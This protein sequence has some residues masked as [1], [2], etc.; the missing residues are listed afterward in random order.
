MEYKYDL[1][2]HTNL[3]SRCA[4][5]GAKET[6]E[7]YKSKGYSGIVVT[8]HYSPLTYLGKLPF[9]SKKEREYF[10][11]GYNELK[12]Y[13]D[14]DFCVLL[15]MEIRFYF[16]TND[17]LV[18]GMTPEFLAEHGNLMTYYLRRFY[19]EIKKYNMILV[20]AHPFRSHVFRADTRLL[21]G[22]E[23]SNAKDFRNNILNRKAREWADRKKMKI[24]TGGSDFHHLSQKDTLGGIITTTRIRTNDDLISVLKSRDFKIIKNDSGELI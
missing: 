11:S 22:C 9:F 16:T 13:E 7:A 6:V 10:L 4:D 23:V 2:C 5:A 17:Y 14:D 8:D 3:V 19:R 20:Q 12:Q 18:Y 21:D 15:G 1:H 24:T